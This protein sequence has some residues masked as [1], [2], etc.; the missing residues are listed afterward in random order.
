MAIF[1]WT[2][3]TRQGETRKGELVA[4]NQEE[5][6][7]QLRKDN[8]IVTAVSPKGGGFTINWN[9]GETVTQQDVAIMTR[10]FA[11]MINAGLPLIQCLEI[12]GGQTSKKVFADVLEQVKN[13]VQ[14][15]STYAQAL[16]KHPKVFDALYVNLVAAGETGGVLDTILNRL[17]LYIE[18]AIKLK[19]KLKSALYYPAAIVSVAV[20]VVTILLVWVIPIFAKLFAE[21]GKALPALTQAVINLSYFLQGNFFL[22]LGGLFLF[23]FGFRKYYGTPNG[24]M[25][26]DRVSLKLP[27]FGD[28]IRKASV[29]RFTR[30]LAT[31]LTS[32][33]PILDGLAIVARI[34]GNKV[35]EQTLMDARQSI[36]EGKLISDPLAKSKVF[37]GMVVQMIAVG[38][39]TGAL[40][41]ML[42]KIA[43]FYDEEVD[44]A[45]ANL[46]TLL[47]PALM[48]F[49]GIVVGTV[50]IAMYLPI[51]KLASVVG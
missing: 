13:D 45:V 3:K 34:A 37:P 16:G 43:D 11:T 26:I 5:V 6:I 8:I 20:A 15:G 28:I 50:V 39:S 17:A 24:R 14:G 23:S 47:E 49:L 27:V 12:L 1:V 30:T 31:L 9:L 35:I 38:E 4:K 51:F 22:I 46:A 40:D 44:V 10:Q 36:S 48:I 21:Y 41:T 19:R 33:V 2:G 25:L 29:A 32:G 7:A 18:K 42:N